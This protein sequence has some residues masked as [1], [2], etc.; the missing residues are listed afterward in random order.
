MYRKIG[1]RATDMPSAVYFGS[2][3]TGMYALNEHVKYAY[4]G[5]KLVSYNGETCAYDGLGNP[6]TYRG[7]ATMFTMGGYL[8]KYDATAFTYDMQGD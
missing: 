6:T 4:D 3:A 1:D 8:T 5:N 7:K 2:K